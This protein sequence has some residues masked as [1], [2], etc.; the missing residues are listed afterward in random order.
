MIVE[1]K[2][3]G[4]NSITHSPF[5]DGKTQQDRNDAM[6]IPKSIAEP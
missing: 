4:M 1:G 3:S 5:Q 6:R 2:G